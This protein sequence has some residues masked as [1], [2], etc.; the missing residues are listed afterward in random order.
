MIA[1]LLAVLTAPFVL[2]VYFGARELSGRISSL[3]LV[4]PEALEVIEGFAANVLIGSA[5]MIVA[6]LALALLASSTISRQLLSPIR[7]VIRGL[8]ALRGGDNSIRVAI[9]GDK[10]LRE[11]ENAFNLTAR[12]VGEMDEQLGRK[13]QYLEV[14]IDPVW[15]VDTSG[16]ITDI[17]PAFTRT[18]GYSDAEAVGSDMLDFLDEGT[19][20]SV[21]LRY[22]NSATEDFAGLEGFFISK[23][24]GRVPVLLSSSNL[25]QDGVA[26]N[27]VG[28]I[29]DFRSEQELIDALRAEK[30][31]TDL[32]MDAIE[33]QLVVIDRNYNILRANRATRVL[34]GLDPIGRTCHEVLIGSAERCF[35]H[36][37]ECPA[38]DTFESG[39][40]HS[41]TRALDRPGG[42]EGH[43]DIHAFPVPDSSG[44]VTSVLLSF[45]DISE[46]MA[47]EGEIEHKNRE[48]EVLNTISKVLS[49]SLRSEDTH[50]EVLDRIIGLFAMDGGGIYLVNDS[51]RKLDC[52]HCR[53]PSDHFAQSVHSMPVGQDIPGK[54]A[55]NGRPVFFQD[56]ST[57]PRAKGSAFRNSGIKAIMC[58]PISGLEKTLGVFFMFSFS[59]RPFTESDERILRSI[60]EMMGISF[61]NIRL[62]EKMRSLYRQ[63]RDRRI[64]EQRD[65]LE[66]SS[67]LAS[68]LDMEKVLGSCL[69]LIKKSC[70]ADY[71]WLLTYDQEGAL[72]LKASTD[73]KF[74]EGEVV[75]GP[76]AA[77]IEDRAASEKKPLM[78]RGISTNQS[79]KANERV[80]D[81]ATVC[82]VPVYLGDRTLGA[83]SLYYITDIA[84]TEEELHFLHI[85]GS[86]ISVALERARL[87][88]SAIIQRGMANTILE[89]IGDGVATVDAEGKV[90]SMNP[91]AEKLLGHEASAAIGRE[92][93]SLMGDEP[94]NDEAREKLAVNLGRAMSGDALSVEVPFTASGKRR[95]P[96]MIQC[97]PV[98]GKEPG[99]A[100]AV[101]VFRDLGQERELDMVMSEFVKLVSEEFRSPLASIAGMTEMLLEEDIK[102]KRKKQ[103]LTSMLSESLR[104]TNLVEDLLDLERME[105]GVV[106]F[107]AADVNMHEVLLHA[108]DATAL[109]AKSKNIGVSI[110][111]D[112]KAALIRGDA[113]LLKQ[114]FRNLLD[115]A[116]VYSDPGA[117][118][119]VKG[120]GD[121]DSV[122]VT[123]ADTGWGI[124]KEELSRVS[125][126]FFRGSN[127]SKTTGTGLGL[128]LCREI[129]A[130]HGGSL[131]IKS[132]K[133]KGT[134]V[135][136]KLAKGSK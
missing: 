17:N 115:N 61:E 57:D 92:I 20:K 2:F 70:W 66:L 23:Q 104:L 68:S 82:S 53:G 131:H 86:V 116:M 60:S 80:K 89:S 110:E 133:G 34:H 45:R 59:E 56:V 93:L 67:M 35:L 130:L 109:I 118:V 15:V 123:I 95:I 24:D 114:L 79:I 120:T 13:A 62:Y 102:G 5:V 84:L 103:Y 28:I 76:G 38:R 48:L 101:L 135:T 7:E 16:A 21:R 55:E 33:D 97:A 88:E 43:Y 69:S 99:A 83:F 50:K 22:L 74:H 64:Q 8:A 124:K 122:T 30:E 32:L 18:F 44:D 77:S 119:K 96:L 51:G 63:D 136:V 1:A 129:A 42:K 75:Y 100:G 94:E 41:I 127:S 29:K 40:P 54:V 11:L 134:T 4:P 14:M 46:R 73:R 3:T 78:L 37:V 26:I 65:L 113:N 125:E 108:E 132:S 19:R 25:Y 52:A 12:A 39:K 85:V 107:S 117:E 36:G 71:A 106:A 91:A 6:C 112:K 47:F 121:R 111:L 72:R 81:F 126:R 87:Y 9:T 49:R 58:A 90:T 10:E 27:R 98:Y 105:S 128:P 31:H